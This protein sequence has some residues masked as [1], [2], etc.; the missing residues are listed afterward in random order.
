MNSNKKVCTIDNELS[1]KE[2]HNV[3]TSTTN[4]NNEGKEIN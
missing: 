2:H 1:I 3:L 4:K